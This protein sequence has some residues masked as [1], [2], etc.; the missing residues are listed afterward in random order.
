MAELTKYYCD[1]CGAELQTKQVADMFG[2]E[3]T[4]ICTGRIDCLPMYDSFDLSRYGIDCCELCAE[5]I[6]HQLNM[7]KLTEEVQS[8]VRKLQRHNNRRCREG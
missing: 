6:S 7:F 3:H 8:Y 4:V 1:C 2:V 5:K